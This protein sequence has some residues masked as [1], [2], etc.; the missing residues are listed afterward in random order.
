MRLCVW[1][2]LAA[3]GAGRPLAGVQQA[4]MPG[5]SVATPAI[6]DPGVQQYSG[7]MSVARDKH[8][9]Y[10]FFEARHRRDPLQ[11]APVILWLN[12]GPGCSS[13]SGLFGGVGPYRVDA[14][15]DGGTRVNGA[16]WNSQAHMLFLDQPANT[17]Y[18]FGANVTRTADAARDAAVFL[19]MFYARFPQYAAGELHVMG[20]SYAAHYVPA[21]AA[22]ILA[23][24]R[25]PGARR[26]PLASIAVG[27][28]LF[29]I[30]RQYMFLPQMA[31]AS[32]TYP[33]A[34]D[35]STCRAM[36]AAR[37]EF[38]RQLEA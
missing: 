25:S 11:P 24:N 30:A 22:R 26:L 5:D 36:E 9:F 3:L 7:Y 12:G 14:D 18:S 4:S 19:R 13:F 8:L 37:V 20:E 16:S 6:C 1:L 15:S 2:A 31:C 27:N 23:E 38:A 29:D 34:V 21:I 33:P 35:A 28:G 10:W 32:P 17:G